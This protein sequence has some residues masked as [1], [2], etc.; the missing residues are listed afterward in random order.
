MSNWESTGGW[1]LK[2]KGVKR[3]FIELYNLGRKKWG[4]CEYGRF[5][6]LLDLIDYC[7][8]YSGQLVC[9]KKK[10]EEVK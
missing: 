9:Q 4:N 2:E 10:I 6:A 3:T 5:R 8:K 7:K 1:W